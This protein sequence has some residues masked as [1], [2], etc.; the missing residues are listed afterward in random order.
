MASESEPHVIYA[1]EHVIA[2]DKPAGIAVHHAAIFSSQEED[3][4]EKT[5]V[6]FLLEKYP[7]IKTVGDDPFLRPGIVH[8]LDKNTSGVMVV[9]RTKESFEGLKNLFKARRVEK[10]YVAV[11]CGTVRGKTGRIDFPIGRLVKNP[12]RRG[13]ERGRSRIRGSRDAVT[14]YRVINAG[15]FYSLLELTPRTGRTHQIRVHL[16]ALGHAVACDTMYG[17]KNVCCP[18]GATRQLLHAR[19]IS[20]SYPEGRRYYFETDIPREFLLAEDS[21]L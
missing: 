4:K 13:V 12:M 21:V 19:S 2:I 3:N 10:K 11:V 6:D 16:K 17:G 1:D 7:E 15:A 8:R 20:F 18:P 9:A 14:E 5:I